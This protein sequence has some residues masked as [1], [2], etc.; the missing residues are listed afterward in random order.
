MNLP[1]IRPAQPG[2]A[3]A[4]AR[5][6]NHYILHTTIT[7]EEES[8]S[9]AQ[10]AARIG[11]LQAGGMP[12]L[13]AEQDA[14]LLGYAYAGKW[15]ARSAYRYAAESTVYLDPD[16]LARGLGSRLY[17]ALFAELKQRGLHVVIGGIAL[18]NERSVALHEKF[19]MTKVAHFEQVGYKFERR[20]DVAYWQKL[21]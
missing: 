21:L 19:G 6:Y 13:V 1:L 7:F 5:I 16:T 20:I 15:K 14:Q 18:P 8:V 10:M 11:E 9:A 12:W 17:E 4:I 2:D 3:E